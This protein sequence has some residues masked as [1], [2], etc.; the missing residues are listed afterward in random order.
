[1][2]DEWG[3]EDIE[4]AL[5]LVHDSL[6]LGELVESADNLSLRLVELLGRFGE[7]A[8]FRQAEAGEARLS[9]EIIGQ[10]AR[11]VHRLEDILDAY[12]E[13]AGPDRGGLEALRSRLIDQGIEEE[14][15]PADNPAGG[16]ERETA[17]E[18]DREEE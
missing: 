8:A 13:G 4:D 3:D 18:D 1:L 14:M 12:R 9:L 15:G 16:A 6:L 5:G 17:D 11:R 7:A 10:L 2:R